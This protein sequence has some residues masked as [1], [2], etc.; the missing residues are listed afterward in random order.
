MT[1]AMMAV[2]AKLEGGQ[3]DE[4]LDLLLRMGQI[5]LGFS[6]EQRVHAI[7]INDTTRRST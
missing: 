3:H 4:M 7:T 6:P 5:Q 2:D 1:H